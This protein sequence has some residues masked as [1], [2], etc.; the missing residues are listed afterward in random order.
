MRIIVA[1]VGRLK[2]G[3][4]TELSER[5]RKRTAQTGRQLGRFYAPLAGHN[6]SRLYKARTTGRQTLTLTLPAWINTP[7]PGLL[8]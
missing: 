7:S 4:E 3:P 1:A 6:F 2:Q 8:G 5:Y